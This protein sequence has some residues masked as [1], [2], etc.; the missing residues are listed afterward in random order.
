MWPRTRIA[1]ALAGLGLLAGIE[2]GA[3]EI[4]F[5]LIFVNATLCFLPVRLHQRAVP[6][7]AVVLLALTLS[8]L[9]ILPEATFY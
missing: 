7:V 1:A 2:V 8:R 3:R 9:G 6:V 4:F 5:G